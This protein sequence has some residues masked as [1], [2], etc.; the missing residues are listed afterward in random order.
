MPHWSLMTVI[1]CVQSQE[2]PQYASLTTTCFVCLFQSEVSKHFQILHLSDVFRVNLPRKVQTHHFLSKCLFPYTSTTQ[3]NPEV[4]TISVWP[5]Q[6]GISWA[7]SLNRPV[8]WSDLFSWW[9][10][11][12]IIPG[13]RGAAC[14]METYLLEEAKLQSHQPDVKAV[15]VSQMLLFVLN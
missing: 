3:T 2:H 6:R 4:D 10:N 11:T 9:T 14:V 5:P 12:E 13:R 1:H 15:R 8:A 7:Q